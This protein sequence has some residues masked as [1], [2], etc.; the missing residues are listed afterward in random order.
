[1]I[2]V[3]DNILRTWLCDCLVMGSLVTSTLCKLRLLVSDPA[4]FL[5]RLGHIDFVETCCQRF[6]D[7]AIVERQRYQRELQDVMSTPAYKQFMAKQLERGRG[8]TSSIVATTTK[9]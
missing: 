8:G 6:K 9:V 5:V 7:G 4:I 1:M 3:V 2:V